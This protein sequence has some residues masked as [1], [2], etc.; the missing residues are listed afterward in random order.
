MGLCRYV[1]RNPVAAGLVATA[2]E[3]AWSSDRA[4]VCMAPDAVLARFRWAARLSVA[5]LRGEWPRPRA[6]GAVV[7]RTG[8]GR[9]RRRSVVV[10]NRSASAGLPWRL[11][12]R[13]SHAGAGVHRAAQ[14]GLCSE[15]AAQVAQHVAGLPATNSGSARGAAHRIPRV[16][17]HDDRDGQGVAAVGVAH[18]PIDCC[19]GGGRR[20]VGG[21]RQD[22]TPQLPPQ[23]PRLARRLAG[24][25][26]VAPC[27]AD[28]RASGAAGARRDA[29]RR[30]HAAA[31]P[32]PQGLS[33]SATALHVQRTSVD[34]GAGIAVASPDLGQRAQC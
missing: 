26:Q 24:L 11:R 17:H 15:G 19:S 14:R 16:R 1:E 29:R 30:E 23:L 7:R 22:L 9:R 25:R 3:W 13:R 8:D 5:P 32:A 12:F 2:D 20:W 28:R 33:A 27:S 31:E 10:A 18:Q 34:L 21:K 6:C 4:H